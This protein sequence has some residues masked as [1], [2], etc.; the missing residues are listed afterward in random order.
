ML[1]RMWDYVNGNASQCTLSKTILNTEWE[2]FSKTFI[3]NGGLNSNGET[4]V[5]AI[6]GLSGV[7][8]IEY[9]AMKLEEGSIATPWISEE[10]DNIY[11][12]NHGF[13]EGYNIGSIN[14]G[15]FL[16]N[17]FYEL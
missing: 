4:N 6:F 1:V 12:G 16:A 13:F 2:H 5:S 10:T 17:E 7:G 8:S 14:R 3:Y 11:V 15:S 9:C